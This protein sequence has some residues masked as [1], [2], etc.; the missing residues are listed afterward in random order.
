MTSSYQIIS[1]HIISYYIISY[2]IVSYYDQLIIQ[3]R[4]HVTVW[5]TTLMEYAFRAHLLNFG[6]F[7]SCGSR[8]TAYDSM[9]SLLNTAAK[10]VMLIACHPKTDIPSKPNPP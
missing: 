9:P 5:L 7:L 8:G 4:K 3:Y 1:Y 10:R 6:S 2:D